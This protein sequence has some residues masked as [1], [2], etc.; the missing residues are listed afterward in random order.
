MT[1]QQHALPGQYPQIRRFV[2]AVTKTVLLFPPVANEAS[3]RPII[4]GQSFH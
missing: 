4:F 2:P 1:G 3:R